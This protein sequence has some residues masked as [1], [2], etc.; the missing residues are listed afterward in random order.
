MPQES[1][2][3]AGTCRLN[4]FRVFLDSARSLFLRL[5]A[6]PCSESHWTLSVPVLSP[7]VLCLRIRCCLVS[8][9][10]FYGLV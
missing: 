7:G 8:R 9:I 6:V 2:K 1:T 5:P 10:A 3:K 4:L